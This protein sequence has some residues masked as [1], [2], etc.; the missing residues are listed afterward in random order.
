MDIHLIFVFEIRFSLKVI[1]LVA[2]RQT[3]HSGHDAENVVV[4]GVYADVPRVVRRDI[5]DSSVRLCATEVHNDSSCINAR[6]V[7]RSGWLVLFR[8]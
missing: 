6:E 2:V 1:C 4:D 8:A 7:A 5:N 3:A